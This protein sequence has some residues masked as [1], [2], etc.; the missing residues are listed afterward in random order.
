MGTTRARGGVA[1]AALGG[2][3][4]ITAAWWA[5][6]LWPIGA[7]MPEW[8]LR[9]RDICFGSRPDGLP[10]AGGWVLLIG[11]PIGMIGVLLVVWGDALR[12]DLV[13]LRGTFGGQLVIGVS[14]VALVYGGVAA[15]E[16]VRGA[17][18]HAEA[19]LF[20]AT[21][22]GAPQLDE[23][24]PP[25]GLVDQRGA[26]FSLDAFRGRPVMVTFAFAHCES[27]CPTVVHELRVA[28]RAAP[29]GDAAIV[30]VTLD[31]WR[32]VPA[33]LPAIAAQWVLEGDDRVLSGAVDDVT[34]V[35]DAWRIAHARD[36]ATGDVTHVATVFLVD[37]AGRVRYR[38]AGDTRRAGELLR[39]L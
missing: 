4:A 16:R 29:A 2:L 11:E 32:D 30:I 1:V 33:R 12:R 3:L 34:R 26:P 21:G 10:D 23:A 25:L 8:V 5:L 22:A 38:L 28:R 17:G 31:P 20:S 15:A 7:A 35:L 19:A 27:V 14:A 9:T 36:A 24:A 13:A 39:T 37:R 18:R 6:A